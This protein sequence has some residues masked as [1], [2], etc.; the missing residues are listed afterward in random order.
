MWD[1]QELT[2]HYHS[3]D[4]FSETRKYKTLWRAQLRA[5]YWVGETPELG[6]WYAVSFDG[7]GR[8]SVDGCTIRD[9]F[10]RSAV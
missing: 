3:I 4:G 7:V 2:L 10:P 5:H 9:L 8:I 6:S 1:G